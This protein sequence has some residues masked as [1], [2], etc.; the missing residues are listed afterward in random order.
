MSIDYIGIFLCNICIGYLFPLSKLCFFSTNFR[1]AI[2][3]FLFVESSQLVVHRPSMQVHLWLLAWFL[4]HF[5]LDCHSY[6]AL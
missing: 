1:V 3:H 5:K 2:G 6:Q 4:S